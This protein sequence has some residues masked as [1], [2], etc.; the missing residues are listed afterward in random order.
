MSLALTIGTAGKS[1]LALPFSSMR[2]AAPERDV[3]FHIILIGRIKGILKLPISF[4]HQED[5]CYLIIPR[6]NMNVYNDRNYL[7]VQGKSLINL[8]YFSLTRVISWLS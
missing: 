8:T 3:I 7:N 2:K 6:C 5:I 4:L 1:G